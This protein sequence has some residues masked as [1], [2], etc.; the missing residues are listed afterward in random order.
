M[1]KALGKDIKTFYDDHFPEGRYHD[2]NELE[3]HRDDGTW[4]LEDDKMYD[5]QECGVIVSDDGKEVLSF[6]AL[7][8]KWLKSCDF[9]TFV[10]HVPTLLVDDFKNVMLTMG[11]KVSERECLVT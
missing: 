2:D 5:L 6:S 9:K 3:F 4:I 8:M 10:I 11:I 7:F 1:A